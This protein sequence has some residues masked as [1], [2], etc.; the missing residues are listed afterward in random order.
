[1]QENRHMTTHTITAMF[2]SR[3]EAERATE[4]LVSQAGISRSTIWVDPATGSASTDGSASGTES[5]GLLASAADLFASDEDRHTYF[6]GMRRGGVFLSVQAEEAQVDRVSEVLEATGAVDLDMREAEWRQSGWAGHS[7]AVATGAVVGAA[8]SGTETGMAATPVA[9]TGTTGGAATTGAVTGRE[10]AITLAEEKLRVGKRTARAGR[11]R[12]HSYVVETPVE[13]QVRL[14]EEHVHVER[15]ALDRP[16][17]GDAAELFRERVIEVD[18]S[19]EEAVVAKETRITGEVVVNKEAVERT[20]TIRD[21][22][23]RTE[24]EVDEENAANTNRTAVG[25]TGKTG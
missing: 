23:R 14:R 8:S 12:V 17:T 1:M 21:S 2:D 9:A 19:V 18:E 11:V 7:S 4:A 3:V 15:H 6:E 25:R 13:E 22:V 5:K 24:V 16:V 20:E 10:E